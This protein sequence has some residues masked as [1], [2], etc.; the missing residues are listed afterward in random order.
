M[1]RPLC[2]VA[3][4]YIGGILLGQ[5]LH[6]PLTALFALSFL[7]AIAALLWSRGRLILLRSLLV[8][9][10]WTN[11]S[12][13]TAIISPG[14][15]RL[16]AGPGPE[17]V[18]VRGALRAS[19]VPRIFERQGRELWH[20]SAVI[21]AGQ[22]RLTRGWQ[23]AFGKII[24]YVP[25]NLPSNFFSGQI[26][27]VSGVLGPPP[28]PRAEGLFDARSYYQH[29]AIYC[30]L[31][32]GSAEAWSVAPATPP[33]PMPLPNRFCAWA[34]KT[35]A[36]GLGP[37]DT[38]LRLIWTLAL[39]W[40]APLTERIEEPFMRAG[41]Y[42]IFAVDG[43][44]I[45]LLA[46]IG[47]GLLRALR[48]PRAVCGLLVIP[49]IW[50]YAGLTGWPASAVRAAIMMSIVIVGWA[51]H[52]P[53]NLVN[54]LFAAA[55]IILLWDPGQLFQ[56]GFQLSFMVVLCIA[57]LLPL[58]RK[59][60]RSWV[61]K[62][63]PFLP[64]TLKPRWPPLLHAA[65]CFAIDTCALSL[66]AWLGSIPLAAAY[67]H[68]FTPVSVPANCLV[69]PITALALMSS[70]GSL[71]TGAWLPGVAVLFNHS[72]WF[73]MR[74]IIE[75]SRWAAHW[76]AGTFNI[77]T[78]APV[79]YALYYLVLFS[80]LT[81][82]IFRSRFRWAVAVAILGLG[83]CWLTQRAAE[84]KTARLHLL[85]L[86]GGS[87]IFADNAG[88]RE[89]MLFDCGNAQ[90]A[91]SVV[92]PFLRAQGVNTLDTLAL[93]VGHV[94]DS[95][96]AKVVLTNFAVGR[97]FINPVRDR[98]PAYRDVIDD[99]KQTAHWQALQA[100]G[101]AGGWLVLHPE[102]SIRFDD[103]DD[104]ALVFW[105]EI[106]GHSILLL[107]TLGRSGQDSLVEKHPNLRTDIAVAGL[108]AEDEP[109][110][111]PLLHLIQPKLI[112]IIDSELPATR[113]ASARLRQR[114]GSHGVPV[115]YCSDAGALK[116]SLWRGGWG[117]KN[118]S[119]EVVRQQ[120]RSEY[121]FSKTSTHDTLKSVKTI[122]QSLLDQA[123][124]R[125]K[126]EFQPEEIYLFGSH[127][128]GVPDQDSDIDLM[129]IVPQSDERPIRRDQRAQRCLG[130]LLLSADVLVRTRG[131]V[132]RV[133]E[134][135]GSL[136]HAVLR[137][138]RKLYG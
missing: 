100:G 62:K 47:V 113:R 19:P 130:R 119:G 107:S 49:V 43:L 132:N 115:I 84:N 56:A 80:V 39:D 104:N 12:W 67:F 23:P 75:L 131:E 24:A 117:L 55:F 41:T 54:S 101:D 35:L 32:T 109:L 124:D 44:R 6:P 26:V 123:V 136:T 40:K 68:L 42:H 46:G 87:A 78:P 118:A 16:L 102:A 137:N 8:L 38:P 129:V 126:A 28:S 93:T 53:A 11:L 121:D 82:W 22:I 30:Q 21:D 5:W 60:F 90:A 37:E 128:W 74:C 63:D 61:F 83:V 52:R 103:A 25:V 58:V 2:S 18:L 33:R 7:S 51:S 69:V 127:A 14:D 106:N 111:E 95:G 98:S 20:S 3:L 110:S 99:I 112:I 85:P 89:N 4:L 17:A 64:E 10:G 66:A 97:V 36:L 34:R 71:L 76:P 13:H 114:L 72:S 94:Q 45:G 133:R 29:E 59:L 81:G 50:F 92:K 122:P 105:R 138:G 79:T 135:Q 48:L 91:E 116:L 27:E 73:F 77:S 88:S 70:I 57:V 86:S 120:E 96:G 125:L 15:L 1:K 9:A 134:V 108:P 65:A 31:R